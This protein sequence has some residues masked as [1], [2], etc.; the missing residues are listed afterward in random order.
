MEP[1]CTIAPPR[2]ESFMAFAAACAAKNLPLRIMPRKRSYSASPTSRNGFGV[3]IP[4]LLNNTSRR[5]NRLIAVFTTASPVAGRAISPAYRSMDLL[6]GT[7]V[8]GN[9][10]VGVMAPQR[11]VESVDL[12]PDR[13]VPDSSQ[14]VLQRHETAPQ[15]RF[16]GAHSNPEV[17]LQVPRAVERVSRPTELHRQPLAEPSMRLSP[18]SAPIRQTCRSFRSASARRVLRCPLRCFGESDSRGS[19]E[20]Q[21]A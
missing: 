7:K 20:Q 4:A 18:H 6:Q 8:S 15:A 16:L 21:S 19:Y 3:K 1:V 5:P 17:A 9:A 14:Q 12:F 10:V 13:Q 11:G 2:P